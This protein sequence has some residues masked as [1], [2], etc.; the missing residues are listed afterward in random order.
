MGGSLTIG[1]V[2]QTAEMPRG[3]EGLG[4]AGPAKRSEKVDGGFIDIQL[5]WSRADNVGG[6][7]IPSQK[8]DIP[9]PGPKAAEGIK[10]LKLVINTS[11]TMTADILAIVRS[12]M[13]EMV[14]V[15]SK[16]HQQDH[17]LM[18]D[19]RKNYAHSV[20]RK[21]DRMHDQ[22]DKS[23]AIGLTTSFFGMA[24]SVS[25]AAIGYNGKQPQ[26]TLAKSQGVAG[27][28]HSLEGIGNS[29]EKGVSAYD[30]AAIAKKDKLA[31]LYQS[32]QTE[33]NDGVQSA[34]QAIR[35]AVQA[36]QE[37]G[38]KDD[39]ALTVVINKLG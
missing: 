31:T 27:V 1:N 7:R 5:T 30:E 10:D 16:L 14:S 26:L 11:L 15:M 22:A 12:L 37:A 23:M 6:V 21:I 9:P 19:S 35:G 8:H 32:F 13:S 24:F 36:L 3:A 28:G 2:P 38:S 4:T 18:S 34:M 20:D 39:S 29:V 33:F 17:Q 25:S